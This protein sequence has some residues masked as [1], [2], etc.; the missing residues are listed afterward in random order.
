[1]DFVLRSGL[2][3]SGSIIEIPSKKQRM[4]NANEERGTVP[5]T[6]QLDQSEKDFDASNAQVQIAHV[7]M[8]ADTVTNPSS[9]SPSSEENL[10]E[11]SEEVETESTKKTNQRIQTEKGMPSTVV[12]ED[13]ATEPSPENLNASSEEVVTITT[14]QTSQCIE[15]DK[16]LPDADTAS[17]SS[18]WVFSHFYL[19]FF[20]CRREI[21]ASD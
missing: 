19:Q 8:E 15:S 11:S 14:E 12:D 4:N 1:M 13:T 21:W 7:P 9:S 20:L 3:K 5:Q 16:D 17:A 2:R 10:N 6:R 18:S